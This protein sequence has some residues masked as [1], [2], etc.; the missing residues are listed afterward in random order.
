MNLQLCTLIA[1]AHHIEK[2]K[3]ELQNRQLHNEKPDQIVPKVAKNCINSP[4]YGT[5]PEEDKHQENT[6]QKEGQNHLG[7]EKTTPIV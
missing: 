5:S 4:K 6:Q 1:R 7:Q 2:I 3:E